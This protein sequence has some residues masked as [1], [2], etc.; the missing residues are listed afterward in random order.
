MLRRNQTYEQFAKKRQFQK[1]ITK[2]YEKVT[3]NVAYDSLLA[4]LYEN[5]EHACRNSYEKLTKS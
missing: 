5:I 4:D 3:K 2:K 1:N